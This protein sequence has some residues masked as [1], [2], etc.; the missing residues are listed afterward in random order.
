[1]LCVGAWVK[2][3]LFHVLYIVPVFAP[4]CEGFIYLPVPALCFSVPHKFCILTAIWKHSSWLFTVQLLSFWN[5]YHGEHF[6]RQER[7]QGNSFPCHVY[8]SQSSIT[9]PCTWCST[10]ERPVKGFF[11]ILRSGSVD[12]TKELLKKWSSVIH[13]AAGLS[14]FAVRLH[15]YMWM[16]TNGFWA[17]WGIRIIA[18]A[19]VLALVIVLVWLASLPPFFLLFASLLLLLCRD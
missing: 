15:F 8:R 17:F 16:Q 2:R 9:K 1:M 11:C 18:V 12:A 10:G 7:Q 5:A 14:F 4:Q 13:F 3:M 19:N 6:Q